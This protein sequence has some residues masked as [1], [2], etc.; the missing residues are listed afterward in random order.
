MAFSSNLHKKNSIASCSTYSH[1][2]T[3]LFYILSRR[4]IDDNWFP[5]VNRPGFHIERNDSHLFLEQWIPFDYANQSNNIKNDQPDYNFGR[6]GNWKRATKS[7]RG[8]NPAV[9]DYQLRGSCKRKIFRILNIG[10]RFNNIKKAHII[11]AFEEAKKFGKSIIAVTNHDYRHMQKSIDTFRN[12]LNEIKNKYNNINIKFSGAEEAA[13]DISN[14]KKTRIVW[15]TKLEGRQL[16]VKMVSGEIF[17]SQPFLAI[18]TKNNLY[19]HENF[20]EI[21]KKRI[22][23]FC[24]DHNSIDIKKVAK[25]GVAAA[26]KNGNYI[27]TVLNV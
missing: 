15:K 7:W 9:E 14:S 17:S 11:E 5:V 23:S 8:Y 2:Y 20:D 16:T 18:K 4:I 19:F 21:E 27:T 10:T 22:W 3:T 1:S 26:G 12:L 6:F 24:F 13:I 25:I